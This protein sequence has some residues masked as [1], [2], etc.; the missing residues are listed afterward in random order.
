MQENKGREGISLRRQYPVKTWSKSKIAT[1]SGT[2]VIFAK[3][4]DYF[5]PNNKQKAREMKIMVALNIILNIANSLCSLKC[6]FKFNFSAFL[7][8]VSNKLGLANSL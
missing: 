7:F 1:S 3:K 5:K 4:R 2:A 8:M 6:I